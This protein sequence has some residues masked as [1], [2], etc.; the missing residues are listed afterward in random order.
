MLYE[1][2][3]TVCV[4]NQ[5]MT[6]IQWITYN[7]TCLC[8]LH[9]ENDVCLCLCTQLHTLT[10]SLH[11]LVYH[12]LPDITVLIPNLLTSVCSSHAVVSE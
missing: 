1:R 8:H 10:H 6:S 2:V 11:A 12:M 9:S 7:Y 4:R 3:Y 5:I